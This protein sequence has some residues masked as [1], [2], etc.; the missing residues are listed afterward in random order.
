LFVVGRNQR[1]ENR[2]IGTIEKRETNDKGKKMNKRNQ[3]YVFASV[4]AV[5]IVVTNFGFAWADTGASN[6]N[7][8]LATDAIK[9]NPTAMKILENIEL[10]KQ[11][12][13]LMQQKQQLA[14]Q[15]NQFIEQQRKL[16]NEYLQNDL[17]GINNGNDL[18][19]PRNAYAVFVTHVDNSAQNL[20]WDQFNFMQEKVQ[21]ARNAMNTVLKNGGTMQEALQAY[22]NEAAIHKNQLV[23]INK[24]LNV[25]Y[26]LADAKVQSL[27]NKDGKLNRNA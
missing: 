5:L 18:T 8:I 13:A 17:A 22:N 23:S 1:G 4:F 3:L 25:K 24:D 20:F 14:D 19:F 9:N 10:F 26:N 12:Y 21:N 11:R 16:A 6:T 2:M 15:Q 7:T 27:F